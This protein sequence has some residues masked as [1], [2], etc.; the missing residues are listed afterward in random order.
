MKKS[1]TLLELVAVI[2][3]IG[4]LAAGITLS[5]SRDRL[6]EGRDIVL[7]SI[8]YA[9]HLALIDDKYIPTIS[10]SSYTNPTQKAKD[11]KFW[12]KKWWLVYIRDINGV[13]P[14]ADDPV[15]GP[16]IVIFSDKPS[17]NSNNKYNRS[18]SI[19]E[20][21]LNPLNY[22]LICGHKYDSG[23]TD[24]KIDRKYNLREY[25]IVKVIVQSECSTSS[26]KL[27]FDSVG[28]PHCPKPDNDSSLNPYD[29]IVRNQ[30]KLTLCADNS[31][32]RKAS[33]CI[34]PQSGYAH[35]CL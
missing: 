33:I 31:C 8:R 23:F 20:I 4:I 26:F 30:I 13:S 32:T 5:L 1:F 35:T 10:L 6:Y 29:K 17:P 16:D 28:R 3:I 11:V 34:E 24:D 2:V 21:A 27:H 25:G 14:T 22:K 18:P 15:A 19:N 12:F 9:Q 7:E